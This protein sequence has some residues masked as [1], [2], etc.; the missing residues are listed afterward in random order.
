M[1]KRATEMVAAVEVTMK[2][3]IKDQLKKAFARRT[4]N[5][6]SKPEFAGYFSRQGKDGVALLV[7]PRGAS[8]DKWKWVSG[9]TPSHQIVATNAPL[10]RFQKFYDPRTKPGNKYGGPGR[11]SGPWVNT[12][13]VRHPGIMPRDFETHIANEEGPSI[14]ALLE[15]VIRKVLTT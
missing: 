11:K 14:I 1:E 10:L 9:G 5:W 8:A 4:S 15:T 13:A 12:P 6:G 7:S 2:G 3:P